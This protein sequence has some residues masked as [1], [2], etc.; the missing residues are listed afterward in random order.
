M[1]TKICCFGVVANA[2]A[3]ARAGVQAHRLSSGRSLNRDR[4]L[5]FRP[6][7]PPFRCRSP[8]CPEVIPGSRGC[9]CSRKSP[10]CPIPGPELPRRHPDGNGL[11]L[12]TPC[13]LVPLDLFVPRVRVCVR[14]RLCVCVVRRDCVGGGSV[15]G[16]TR[17]LGRCPA[18]GLS[19]SPSTPQTACLRRHR[20]SGGGRRHTAAGKSSSG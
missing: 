11:A 16:A 2:R 6:R 5:Q 14:C 9:P 13:A 17:R 10:D 4:R 8:C 15:A 3:S 12:P 19:S 18:S 7:L 20:H 1:I